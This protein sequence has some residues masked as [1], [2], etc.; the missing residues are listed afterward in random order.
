MIQELQ[1]VQAPDVVQGLKERDSV[2]RRGDARTPDQ[3]K[4]TQDHGKEK[5]TPAQIEGVVHELN[6]VVKLLNTRLSFSID[7]ETHR[8]VVKV[9]DADT[10]KVIRQIPAEEVMRVSQRI[11]ELL[12]ILVDE[13]A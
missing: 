4:E 2:G 11:N 7:K 12:G 10:Q 5:L 3:D 1:S 9:M 13:T 8:T 6:D